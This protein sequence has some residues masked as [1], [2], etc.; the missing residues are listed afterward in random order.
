LSRRLE[1]T[2]IQE[3]SRTNCGDLV[4]LLTRTGIT[5]FLLVQEDS[6]GGTCAVEVSKVDKK[7]TAQE[8]NDVLMVLIH[9]E[10]STRLQEEQA[11]R[12]VPVDMDYSTGLVLLT[13]RPAAGWSKDW[14]KQ[15]LMKTG[16][17]KYLDLLFVLLSAH[18]SGFKSHGQDCEDWQEKKT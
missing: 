14:D 10:Q 5:G 6:S 1:T 4:R 7:V 12:L 3:I 18:G 2:L 17:E 9:L 16:S 13:R 8:H 15:I 11:I